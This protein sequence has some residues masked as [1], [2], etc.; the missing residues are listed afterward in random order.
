[1]LTGFNYTVTPIEYLRYGVGGIIN[2][3]TYNRGCHFERYNEALKEM[4]KDI[5]IKLISLNTI[6]VD[7]NTRDFFAFLITVNRYTITPK[8]TLTAEQE[9]CFS[10]EVCKLL[11]SI[12][13]HS[14]KPFFICETVKSHTDKERAIY[15]NN[16]RIQ[17]P[18]VYIW[19]D[20][21]LTDEDEL[22]IIRYIDQ[23]SAFYRDRFNAAV[24]SLIDSST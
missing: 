8:E 17:L 9:F 23:C 16:N 5:D 4:V 15:F 6:T 18:D 2:P 7:N 3:K 14:L 12:K 22:K 21:Y 10:A 24:E 20:E 11:E 13:S 19:V 1:V